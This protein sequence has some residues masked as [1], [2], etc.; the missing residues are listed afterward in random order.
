MASKPALKSIRKSFDTRVAR[1][2]ELFRTASPIATT[3]S[4]GTGLDPSQARQVIGLAFLQMAQSTEELIESTFVRY[5]AGAVAPSGAHPALRLGAASD[6]AHAYALIAGDP[7]HDPSSDYLSWTKWKGTSALAVV[8]FVGGNPFASLDPTD[9][10]HFANGLIIRNRVAHDSEKCKAD[11]KALSLT[12]LGKPSNGTLF[13][14]FNVGH[15]LTTVSNR[16]FGKTAPM[17]AFF[18]HYHDAYVRI[19]QHICPA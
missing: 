3:G 15:L 4:T 5:V 16:G 1:A 19:G 7:K 13:Q 17:Q 11:F 9:Q 12:H 10:Q 8:F 2:L 14:G 18:E 6:I